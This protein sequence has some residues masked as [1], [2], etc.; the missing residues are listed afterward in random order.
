MGY[1]MYVNTAEKHW[2][3]A[4]MKLTRAGHAASKAGLVRALIDAS[5]ENTCARRALEG[6]EGNRLAEVGARKV[7]AEQAA[8]IED[9]LGELFMSLGWTDSPPA[10]TTPTA[11]PVDAAASD[12]AATADGEASA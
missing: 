11:G 2:E 7:I 3:E 12:P 6:G 4:A 8:R 10:S 5:V 9:K 1:S